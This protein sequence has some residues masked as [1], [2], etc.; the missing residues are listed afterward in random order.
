MQNAVLRHIW[1]QRASVGTL[2]WASR[3]L[4]RYTLSWLSEMGLINLPDIQ[5]R[6]PNRHLWP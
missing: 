3:A 2:D 6:T 5:S 4:F 1:N